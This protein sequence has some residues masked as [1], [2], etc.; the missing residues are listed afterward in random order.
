VVAI[1]SGVRNQDMKCLE[2]TSSH[3]RASGKYFFGNSSFV[4]RGERQC[5]LAE[6]L[7]KDRRLRRLVKQAETQLD[8]YR[9]IKR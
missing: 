6:R 1:K 2:E 5:H 4:M 3:W 8:E 7:P 9:R